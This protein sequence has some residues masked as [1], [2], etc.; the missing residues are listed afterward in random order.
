MRLLLCEDDNQLA[1]GLSRALS[2]A[3]HSVERAAGAAEAL[4][5]IRA[6]VPD[7]ALVDLSLPDGHGSEVVKRLRQHAHVGIIV[8]TAY[9]DERSRVLGLRAG[10]DDYV[11]K[12]FS[13]AELLARIDAVARRTRPLRELRTAPLEYAGF[14]LESEARLLH[15]PPELPAPR[16][17]QGPAAP[18][19]A[20]HRD[21]AVQLTGKEA[22]ILALLMAHPGS[23]VPRE[24]FLDEIWPS[25]P[26]SASRSLDTHIGALRAK[27]P[28]PM[29]I[30][31]V[32]GVGYLLRAAPDELVGGPGEN[33][34]EEAGEGP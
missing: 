24:R 11:V 32:R 2:R 25:G 7:L 12:P 28:P 10:A 9:G 1:R 26:A 4:R 5:L 21:H 18:D 3:G 23:T 17:D 22:A 13:L 31:T 27:L 30:A 14:R 20:A 6:G 8:I 29:E 15:L 34:A 19:A 33:R 16:P